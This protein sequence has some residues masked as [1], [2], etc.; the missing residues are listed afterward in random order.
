MKVLNA[1]S[2]QMLTSLFEDSCAVNV[3]FKKVSV[4]YAAEILEVAGCESHVGHAD[5]AHIMS[6]QLGTTVAFNRQPTALSAG[7]IALICQYVG[8]RL[9]EGA[10]ALPEGAELRWYEVTVH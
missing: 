5:I 7:E 8:G 6:E 10:T 3:T 4:D 1:F 2:L 9:P